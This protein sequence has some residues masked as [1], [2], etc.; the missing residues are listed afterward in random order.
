MIGLPFG[1]IVVFSVGQVPPAAKAL[2]AVRKN[3]IKAAARKKLAIM[4][5]PPCPNTI[6][7]YRGRGL[8]SYWPRGQIWDSYAH[9]SFG[10]RK[11]Q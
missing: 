7:S 9:H 8:V 3:A 2:P 6:P 1:S 10:E 11:A 4:I 5:R